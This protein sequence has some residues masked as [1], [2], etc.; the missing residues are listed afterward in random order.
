MLRRWP[1]A[2]RSRFTISGCVVWSVSYAICISYPGG[3]DMSSVTLYTR[4][5]AGLCLPVLSRR[6]LPTPLGAALPLD[7]AV[8]CGGR[9]GRQ[10][11]HLRHPHPCH[12]LDPEGAIGGV[13]RVADPDGAAEM[14]HDRARHGIDIVVTELPPEAGLQVAQ[15]HVPPHEDAPIR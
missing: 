13:N 6:C 10:H 14:F 15:P 8:P 9:W 4:G 1:S 11:G 7:G 2:R 12:M 5:L 3:E